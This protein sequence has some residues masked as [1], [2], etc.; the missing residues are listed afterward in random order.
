MTKITKLT[1]MTQTTK[2]TKLTKMIKTTKVTKM[3]KTVKI[4]KMTKKADMAKTVK[5]NQKVLKTAILYAILEFKVLKY[6]KAC[7]GSYSSSTI[8]NKTSLDC[9]WKILFD[10]RKGEEKKIYKFLK[11][12]E[13]KK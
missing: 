8:K 7:L 4:I 3:T 11:K 5:T 12:D 6:F 2:I 13:I 1:K 9:Y 10:V